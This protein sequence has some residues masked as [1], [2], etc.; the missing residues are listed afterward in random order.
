MTDEQQTTLAGLSDRTS[1]L[2]FDWSAY[3]H[4]Y[5]HPGTWQFWVYLL[6]FAV[7]LAALVFLLDRSK[8]Y[9][10][11]FYGLTIHLIAVQVDLYATS[12]RM[13]VY[14]YR[15]LPTATF[16]VGLD[17]SLIPV[18]YMLFYQ[19]TLNSRKNYYLCL[20]GVAFAFSF[21]F[22]PLLSWLGLFLLDE[23]PYWQLFLLYI[24]G[25]LLGKWITDLFHFA[26]KTAYRQD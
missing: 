26:Q 21:L 3:W 12:H 18:V 13:W 23:S 15:L 22:K 5:S 19:W 11:G 1:S 14:P 8:A 25:G 10:L 20:F 17:V 16:S 4:Q 24:A 6:T 9:R 7:P 2:A